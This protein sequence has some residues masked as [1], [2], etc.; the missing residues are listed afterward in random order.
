VLV[1]AFGEDSAIWQD[2]IG[3]LAV[4]SF[5]VGNLAALRQANVKRMLAYSTIGH[6]GFLFTAVAVHTQAAA[7]AMFY[8]LAIYSLMNIGAFALVAIRERELGRPV[9]IDDFRGYAYR[10]PLLAISMVV[11]MLSLAGLPP[12]GGFIAKI[13]IW[14][15]AV[16]TGQTYLAVVGVAATLV[17]LGYYLKIPFALV[18]RDVAVPESP[19]RPAFAVTSATVLATAVAVMVLGIIPGPLLDLAQT[20]SASLIGR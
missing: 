9:L 19:Y 7:R 15:S 12:M 14:S 5:A 1:A 10:R 2:A 3:A 13:T 18:D 11:F 6:T 16:D 4:V 20:A 17:G 8:Y